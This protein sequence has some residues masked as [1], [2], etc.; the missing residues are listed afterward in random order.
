MNTYLLIYL[1]VSTTITTTISQLSTSFHLMIE[2]R[3]PLCNG[4]FFY[5]VVL[6][7]DSSLSL[8]MAK[9]LLLRWGGDPRCKVLFTDQPETNTLAGEIRQLISTPPI[10]ATVECSEKVLLE[11][12]MLLC[13]VALHVMEIF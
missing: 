8:G 1:S 3:H 10:I 11:V 9:E 13:C 2:N 5:Q 7:T 6:V 12:R 4:I